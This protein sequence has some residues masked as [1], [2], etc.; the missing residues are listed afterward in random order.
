MDFQ[1]ETTGGRGEMTFE[2][3]ADMNLLNNIYLS[4]MVKKGTFFAKPDFGCRWPD[5]DKNTDSTA[6]LTREYCLE[7]LQWLLDNGRARAIEVQV[8]RNPDEDRHRLKIRVAAI[9]AD[10]T[11]ITFETYR[12]VI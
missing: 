9:K 2:P 5:R 10:L 7:A 8:E 3:A 6:A 4:L 12:E 1:I 11:Q